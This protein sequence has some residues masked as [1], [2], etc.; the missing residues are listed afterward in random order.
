MVWECVGQVTRDRMLKHVD[1]KGGSAEHKMV[2][3]VSVR[4][5]EIAAILLWA[6]GLVFESGHR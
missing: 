5:K 1:D 6:G 2:G 4:Q 3:I